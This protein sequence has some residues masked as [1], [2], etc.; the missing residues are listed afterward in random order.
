MAERIVKMP[1]PD[2]PIS[3]ERIPARVVVRAAGQV[4]GSSQRA[5]RLREATY[6]AVVY[7]PR[8]DMDMTLLERTEHKSYCPYKGEASYFSIP[9]SGG[10]NAAWSY[11]TPYPSVAEIEGHIAFYADRVEIDEVQDI[12]E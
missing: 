5:L 11:E 10:T 12:E 1:G 2:H 6:P 8:P 4:I 9:L 3:I 7:M